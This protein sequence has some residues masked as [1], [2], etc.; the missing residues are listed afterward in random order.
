ML[1]ISRPTLISRNKHVQGMPLL[2]ADLEKLEDKLAQMRLCWLFKVGCSINS[3]VGI[4]VA[5]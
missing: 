3:V 5:D 2:V 1:Y 4:E